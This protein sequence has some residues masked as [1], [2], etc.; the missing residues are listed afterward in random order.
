MPKPKYSPCMMDKAKLMLTCHRSP[1]C[2][3][4]GLRPAL[5]N[6]CADEGD[7]LASASLRAAEQGLVIVAVVAMCMTIYFGFVC[8]QKLV[9]YLFGTK[10]RNSQGKQNIT[11]PH[12]N[13]QSQNWY[14]PSKL[15]T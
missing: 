5:A 15:E 13:L 7:S 1:H 2:S 14:P 4:K 8:L 3:T 11:L 12:A 6:M 9:L 10:R